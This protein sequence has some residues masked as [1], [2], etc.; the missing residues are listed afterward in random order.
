MSTRRKS[1]TIPPRS[2]DR[3]NRTRNRF[4]LGLLLPA[5]LF[6]CGSGETATG[7]ASS[8]R[9]GDLLFTLTPDKPTYA[10]GEPVT[11]TLRFTYVGDSMITI[12]L[13]ATCYVP[14]ARISREWG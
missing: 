2:D 10:V 7:S 5:L 11:L 14:D 13:G 12:T 1:P 4:A 3:M 6:G 9:F 8:R